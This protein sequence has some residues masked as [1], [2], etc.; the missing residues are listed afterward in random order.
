M[1]P[2]PAPDF[3]SR[4]AFSTSGLRGLFLVALVP[5]LL[6]GVFLSY[7]IYQNERSNLEQGS[8]RTARALLK[9]IDS[10]LNR[11][12]S[13]AIALSKSENLASH[14]LAAFYVEANEVIKAVG[15]G[16]N[17]VL[18]NAQGQQLINTAKP[19]GEPLPLHG[20]PAQ[21]HRI[22][23]T[24]RPAISN[25]YIGA[26]LQRPLMSIDVPVVH[27]GK[28][29]QVLSIGLLPEQFNQLL[30]DQKL[31]PGWIATVL[32]A[33]DTVVAR[34]IAPEKMIMRKATDDLRQQ[35]AQHGQGTMASRSLEGRP[36]FIAFEKSSLTGWTVAVGMTQDVLLHDL[37]RLLALVAL[38]LAFFLGS[39]V[40]LAWVF[41]RRM[42]HALAALG[43]ATQAATQGE[44]HVR[45]P[46]SSGIQE[47]DLL[48]QQFN[49][50]HEARR[51]REKQIQDLAFHD[52]LTRQANRRLLT[53]RLQ[54][55]LA[56][57]QRT[58]GHGAL[59]FLDLDNFKA[60]NDAQ[61]HAAGDLLLI[62][63]AERLRQCVRTMDTVARFGGDEFVVLIIDLE[64]DA[65]AATS[66]ALRAAEKIRTVLAQP[67]RLV[68]QADGHP[69]KVVE[70]HCTASVGVALFSHGE[71]DAD[72]ILERA[73]AAMYQ[74]KKAGR[75]AV[76]LAQPAPGGA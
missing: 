69:D 48:A 60:L 49:A 43:A 59:A 17:F 66:A 5:G 36:T 24:G 7:A 67:Y 15:S 23:R 30:I 35:I 73:D 50:M 45:A 53:D 37:Y 11:T 10:E 12:Q 34:N 6:I 51:K 76:H 62:D 47:I 63:V 13:I 16:N 18:S 29:D 54:Q 8:Q 42:R 33:Q 68:L 61:G 27:D 75:N 26:A 19:L 31:P 55:S 38:S 57:N 28:T 56:R 9:T 71:S 1:N 72:A 64:A 40:A 46:T 58:L 32:D 65:S 20:N 2:L 14:R 4:W 44:A 25:L 39:G 21:L 3:L 52:Q 70:H 22:L 74:A 41:S